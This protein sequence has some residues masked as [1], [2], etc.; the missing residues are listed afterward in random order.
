MHMNCINVWLVSAGVLCAGFMVGEL[1]P[2]RF[3]V[4]FK[5]ASERLPADQSFSKE[6]RETIAAVVHNAGIYNAIVAG[7]LF[8]AAFAGGS[9]LDVAWVMFVGAIAAGIFGAITLGSVV[10]AFRALLGV[11]VLA[12]SVADPRRRPERHSR[13]FRKEFAPLKATVP[14]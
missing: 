12:E 1:F 10:P 14:W 7:G 13:Q 2:W 9:A 3:P 8:Y 6:Q 5:K 4:V 11:M